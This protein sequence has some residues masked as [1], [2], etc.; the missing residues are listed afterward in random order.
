MD[1]AERR[2][3]QAKQTEEAI[4]RA[5]M[6]LTREKRFDK[7]SVRDICKAAGITTG[8]FYHHF[9]SK[10]ELLNKGFA[11][12]DQYMEQAMA[13][14]EGEPPEQRLRTILSVYAQ[15]IEARGWELVSRYYQRRL[16]SADAPPMDPS[17]FTHRA[18]LDCLREA[19]S[20]GGAAS[21]P[22]P[23][24]VADFLFR[25]FRGVVIDWVLHQ[26]AYPL[27]PKLEQDYDFFQTIFQQE[28]KEAS[29]CL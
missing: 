25:H 5:A 12:L 15:F 9:G 22:S 29:D 7:V 16:V 21:D 11:P 13:L 19:L 18:M 28:Q 24:W 20:Q 4:L 3:L 26:G 2:R 10:E 14:H 17:R 27:L 23:E 8:A 6:E 1:Y